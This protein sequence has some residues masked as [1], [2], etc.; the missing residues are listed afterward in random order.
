M[1]ESIGEVNPN[2]SIASL[3][4]PQRITCQRKFLLHETADH[5]Q[6]NKSL[7]IRRHRLTRN[8]LKFNQ[9]SL[10]IRKKYVKCNKRFIANMVRT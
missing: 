4:L 2:K 6:V 1:N 8:G 7:L 9:V 5:A 10:T 3:I